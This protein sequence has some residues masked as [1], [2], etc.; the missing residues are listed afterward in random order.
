MNTNSTNILQK[1]T[2]KSMSQVASMSGSISLHFWR[3]LGAKLATKSFTS[4][5]K[6]QSKKWWPFRSINFR[7][8]MDFGPKMEVSRGA[9]GLSFRGLVGFVGRLGA[10]MAPNPPRNRFLMN[11]LLIF[12]DLSLLFWSMLDGFGCPSLIDVAFL[13]RWI[14]VASRRSTNHAFKQSTIPTIPHSRHGGGIGAQR[15]WIV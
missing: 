10:K 4:P 3:V 8:L 12:I 1:T 7:I 9:R 6:N 2:L 13:F 15:T 5:S 14:F 11:F